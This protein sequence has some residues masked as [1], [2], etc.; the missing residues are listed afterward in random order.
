M[1][2]SE[3]HFLAEVREQPAALLALLEHLDDFVAVG[4]A[5]AERSP[6]AL[7]LVGHG[8]SDAAASS[9]LAVRTARKQHNP[10]NNIENEKSTKAVCVPIGSPAWWSGCESFR[11]ESAWLMRAARHVR[12][13]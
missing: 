6:T 3:R 4:R 1:N 13:E 9:R 5:C 2:A 8:S 7:R 11:S 10:A 12:K